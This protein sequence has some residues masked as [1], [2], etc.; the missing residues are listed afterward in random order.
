MRR[1]SQKLTTALNK[2]GEYLQKEIDIPIKKMKSDLDETETTCMAILNKQECVTTN[3]MLK[4]SKSIADMKE[5]V[6]SNNANHVYAS[7]PG[8]LNMVD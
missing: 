8:L 2:N 1:N 7:N 4:I 6:N 3:K 5:L